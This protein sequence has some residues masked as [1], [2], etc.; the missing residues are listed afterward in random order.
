MKTFITTAAVVAALTL[1]AF[2]EGSEDTRGEALG[3]LKMSTISPSQDGPTDRNEIGFNSM[4]SGSAG[5]SA[6]V[7]S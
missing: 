6:S 3:N 1:P 5:G 4:A 2:G 7:R